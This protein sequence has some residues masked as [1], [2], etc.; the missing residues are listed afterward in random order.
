MPEKSIIAG[1][2]I[3]D[4]NRRY[5]VVQ[6]RKAKAYGLWSFPGGHVDEGET[7]QKAAIRET[8]EEVGL[9][10]EIIYDKPI[11]ETRLV[12]EPNAEYT[13]FLAKIVGGSLKIDDEELLDAKWLYPDEVAAL[14]SDGKTREPLI[15][16]AILKAETYENPGH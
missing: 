9:D 10:V 7:L 11:L 1:A 4:D 6:E 3:R 15:Y 14:D 2:V 8:S 12:N 5:L 16:E 13:A